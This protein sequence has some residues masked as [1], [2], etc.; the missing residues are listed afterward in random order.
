MD[1]S[2]TIL[3]LEKELRFCNYGIFKS[4]Y[5]F[6]C[7]SNFVGSFGYWFISLFLSPLLTNLIIFLLN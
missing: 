1:K 7:I 5:F 3:I 4:F 6:N 2:L